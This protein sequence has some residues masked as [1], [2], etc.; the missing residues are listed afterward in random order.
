MDTQ[1]MILNVSWLRDFGVT[2]H[3]E[4]AILALTPS[5]QLNIR[6]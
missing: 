6:Q 1:R 5:T 2:Q 4:R 3:L